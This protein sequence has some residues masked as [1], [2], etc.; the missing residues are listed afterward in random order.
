MRRRQP[1]KH[2][3][4]IVTEGLLFRGHGNEAGYE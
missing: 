3:L 1:D 2:A 4:V